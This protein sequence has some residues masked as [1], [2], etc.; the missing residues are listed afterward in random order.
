M[1]ENTQLAYFSGTLA[2]GQVLPLDATGSRVICKES[3]GVFEVRLNQVGQW[4]PFEVGLSLY[5]VPGDSFTKVEIRN[6]GSDSI[7]YGLYV[8]TAEIEDDR[9]NALID[10]TVIVSPE[11]SLAHVLILHGNLAAGDS[12]AIPSSNAERF[13]RSVVVANRSSTATDIVYIGIASNGD[14]LCPVRPGETI[15]YM[16]GGAELQV[17]NPTAGPVALTISAQYYA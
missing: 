6:T 5:C 16:I 17:N 3:S 10:R 7:T 9:L 12:E 14:E 2:A 15:E 13:V 8:G 11:E 4:L 1:L